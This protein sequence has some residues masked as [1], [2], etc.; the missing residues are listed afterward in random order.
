M[1]VVFFK[2]FDSIA[3]VVWSIREDYLAKLNNYL[4]RQ[5]SRYSDIE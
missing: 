5:A 1:K 3:R 4:D 2:L